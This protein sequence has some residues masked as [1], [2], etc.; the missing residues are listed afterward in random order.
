MTK[1][2]LKTSRRWYLGDGVEALPEPSWLINGVLPDKSFAVLYGEPGSGKSFLAL[3]WA[4]SVAH[5]RPWLGRSVSDGDV[6]L[7]A[8]EDASDLKYR[9]RAWHVTHMR[10]EK[11][12]EERVAYMPEAWDMVN[13]WPTFIKD[14]K[15]IGWKPRLVIVDT[16]ARCFDG[17]ENSAQELGAF[18]KGCDAV[19]KSFPR[20]TVLVVHHTGKDA[21]RGGRG[22]SALRGACDTE[23]LLTSG[24]K[25]NKRL[26]C[27]KMKAAEPFKPVIWRL[28]QVN[29]GK[30]T[31]CSVLP[32]TVTVGVDT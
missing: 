16:L 15:I 12:Y 2:A 17:D 18:I 20:A 14:L 11:D 23:M 1:P 13:G 28:G 27:Q 32:S 31:S 29:V 6:V 25:G 30:R 19:R 10:K 7:V 9:R 21:D 8:A 26:A 24:V 3:D 4:L 5:A 22:S